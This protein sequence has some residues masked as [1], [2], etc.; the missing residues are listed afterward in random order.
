MSR[1]A[2]GC[3]LQRR[4]RR[5]VGKATSL[6]LSL[7]LS[8]LSSLSLC[9]PPPLCGVSPRAHC[10]LCALCALCG[11]TATL[12]HAASVACRALFFFSF[13]K[14]PLFFSFSFGLFFCSSPQDFDTHGITR[15]FSGHVQRISALS[16]SRNGRYLLSA[17]GDWCDTP[18]SAFF[19]FSYFFLQLRCSRWAHP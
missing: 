13:C 12:A 7:S 16:W 18:P 19:S 11:C 15:M 8:S 10:A 2:A 1:L 9:P 5:G 6:S 4:P 3:R 17:S 14:Y